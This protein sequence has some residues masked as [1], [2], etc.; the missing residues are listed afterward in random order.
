MPT[1]L[2]VTSTKYPTRRQGQPIEPPD[3]Y[4]FAPA[5]QGRSWI[6]RQPI[7]YFHEGNRGVRDGKWKLVMKYQ[8]E[9]ELYDMDA[10]RTELRNLAAAQPIEQSGWQRNG[11]PGQPA[12]TAILGRPG[13]QQLGRRNETLAAA[14]PLFHTGGLAIP[15]N[16]SR[17]SRLIQLPR[18]QREHRLN[19][20]NLPCHQPIPVNPQENTHAKERDSL[21]PIHERMILRKPEPVGRCQL[22]DRTLRRIRVP[23]RG[24]CQGPVQHPLIPQA[25]HAAKNGKTLLVK[26]E[27]RLLADPPRSAHLASSRKVSRY[28]FMNSRPASSSSAIV[29]S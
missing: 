25:G 28:S 1:I 21:I 26:Q 6:R 17:Q 13:P 20:I 12:L 4:S 5:F 22:G 2:S 27:Q 19:R 29:G 7:Y 15:L 16:P 3:G 18:C 14:G 23:I 24:S 11:T 8:A 9:W 10:D